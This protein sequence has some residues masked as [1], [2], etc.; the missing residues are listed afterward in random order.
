MS[1]L[2][3]QEELSSR[4]LL[5]GL[6]A[7][8]VCAVFSAG[9]A[10][11]RDGGG[12]RDTIL[13][14]CTIDALLKGVYD[15]SMTCGELRRGGDVGIGTFEGLDGEMIVLDGAVLKVGMDGRPVP[16][17]DGDLTPFATVT[18]FETDLA[19]D[20]A[21][22]DYAGFQQ[23]VSARL[24]SENLFYAIR[25][26]GR[27]DYMRTRSV[28]KQSK[29]YPPLADVVKGQ[30]VFEMSDVEGTLIGFWC[31]AFVKGVN[32][33]GYH[34]HFLS[35]DRTAGGHVLDFRLDAASVQI[36][37]SATVKVVLPDTGAFLETDLTEDLGAE[38]HAVE[39]DRK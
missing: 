14:V 24:P 34:L 35:K 33:P 30:A 8:L 28:P 25:A 13:Q 2:T 4:R 19:F 32:V 21:G 36:D 27:F 10:A 1:L 37:V 17:E 3:K 31:P 26:D 39:K 20:V 29:P 9:C 5:S 18:P 15:G 12:E 16:Q 7:G 38:L 11:L 23:A 22:V 6:A